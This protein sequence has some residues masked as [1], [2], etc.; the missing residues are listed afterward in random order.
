MAMTLT[1]AAS[2][3][4][5]AEHDLSPEELR[6]R[7]FEGEHSP[8]E[9]STNA[10]SDEKDT[11]QDREL[12]SPEADPED[13][14]SDDDVPPLTSPTMLSHEAPEFVPRARPHMVT[15]FSPEQQAADQYPCDLASATM[16]EI[17]EF[18]ETRFAFP[19]GSCELVN[20]GSGALLDTTPG[21][22]AIDVG[23]ANHSVLIARPKVATTPGN[24]TPPRAHVLM[25]SGSSLPMA[26]PMQ[27][28]PMPQPIQQPQQQGTPMRTVTRV[29]KVITHNNNSGGSPPPP[30]QPFAQQPFFHQSPQRGLSAIASELCAYA[31]T[32][33][34]ARALV[35]KIDSLAD[36]TPAVEQ[37]LSELRTELA[38]LCSQQHG[39]KVV[40]ALARRASPE[41]ATELMRALVPGVAQAA[42]STSG[43]EV[44][45]EVCAKGVSEEVQAEVVT[46]LS[47]SL[48]SICCTVQGR[49]VLVTILSRFGPAATGMVYSVLADQ[50]LS[51]ATDQCGCITIQRCIDCAVAA[52]NLQAHG[53]LQACVLAGLE[54]LLTDPYGNY[55][56]QHVVKVDGAAAE[57]VAA[58]VEGRLGDYACN[59]FASNVVERC[60]ENGSQQVKERIVG[61]VMMPGVVCGLIN[62]AFGNFVVQSCVDYAPPHMID[63]LRQTIAPLVA[64]SPYGYRI[65]SKLQR[66]FRRSAPQNQQ[67][68][69]TGG[70]AARRPMGH[71]PSPPP[72]DSHSPQPRMLRHDNL[73]IAPPQFPITMVSAP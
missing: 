23:I 64:G 56:V 27:Q 4:I 34:G 51:L 35:Q 14:D 69:H 13:E 10:A 72:S 19:P 31:V 53:L 38:S 61:E 50:L 43:S 1:D 57:A 48:P 5:T 11:P 18:A 54:H 2:V 9:G 40:R 16:Q 47:Q 58:H 26:Q 65:E 66:R 39:S 60:L 52:R 44:L 21:A 36:P 15:V 8:S 12:E 22:K 49:K 30:A 71:S 59:K 73:P 17:A 45:A 3:I 7:D 46:M 70:Y 37:L 28:M 33:D 55:V 32:N 62:D 41:Q 6:R 20:S 68:R 67:R 63:A 25:N 42:V 24:C 29:I